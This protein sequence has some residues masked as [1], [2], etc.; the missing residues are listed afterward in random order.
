MISS[1]N[2][3][4]G[5]SY[6]QVNVSKDMWVSCSAFRELDEAIIGG[7]KFGSK[8]AHFRWLVD[9]L[10]WVVPAGLIVVNLDREKA[11]HF[12]SGQ[13][14]SSIAVFSALSYLR[15]WAG[16]GLAVFDNDKIAFLE[17]HWSPGSVRTSIRRLMRMTVE[18]WNR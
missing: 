15:R 13:V 12:R 5:S 17:C 2:A 8:V 9:E 18:S 3:I 4:V 7:R 14:P 6:A 10:F 16:M 11:I 1:L